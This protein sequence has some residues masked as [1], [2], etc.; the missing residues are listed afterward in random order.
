MIP[1]SRIMHV[2]YKGMTLHTIS[3]AYGSGLRMFGIT[4]EKTD[5]Q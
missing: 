1:F 2:M 3:G 4:M 5:F